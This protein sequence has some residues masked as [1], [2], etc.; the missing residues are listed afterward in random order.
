MFHQN[1]FLRNQNKN[2]L[3]I[4]IILKREV[5]CQPRE[6][7]HGPWPKEHGLGYIGPTMEKSAHQSSTFWSS[8]SRDHFL[9][10]LSLSLYFISPMFTRSHFGS[11]IWK[12]GHGQLFRSANPIQASR[13][14]RRPPIPL[15]TVWFLIA[16]AIARWKWFHWPETS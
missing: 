10:S 5:C 2:A 8:E 16:P 12:S 4:L 3:H 9:F 15:G 1:H 13:G 14:E 7:F 11:Q 6:Y